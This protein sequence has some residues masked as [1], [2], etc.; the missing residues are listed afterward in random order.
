LF[1][2]RKKGKWLAHPFDFTQGRLFAV[3]KGWAF[4]RPASIGFCSDR[5]RAIGPNMKSK[6][7]GFEICISHSFQ[8]REGTG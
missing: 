1:F 7:Q 3:Y 4:V 6:A 5:H 8:N 2:E